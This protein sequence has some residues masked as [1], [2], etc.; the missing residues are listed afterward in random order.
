M[1]N[2]MGVNSERLLE[3]PNEIHQHSVRYLNEVFSYRVKE[4]LLKLRT[5]GNCNWLPI[6]VTKEIKTMLE[7]NV[8]NDDDLPSGS[9]LDY[10][11]GLVNECLGINN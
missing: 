9:W 8:C 5:N 7:E 1:F 6:R 10:I 11:Q 4:G 2:T 3:L